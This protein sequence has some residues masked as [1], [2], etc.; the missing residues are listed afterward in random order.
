MKKIIQICM[1]SALVLTFG[2]TEE[3]KRGKVLSKEG[4][5]IAISPMI[6]A[7]VFPDGTDEGVD[8]RPQGVE[9]YYDTQLAE[10]ISFQ[11]SI[12]DKLQADLAMEVDLK[13]MD[14]GAKE[15][16]VGVMNNHTGELL[17]LT[18]TSKFDPINIKTKEI[19]VLKDRFADFLFEP[20]LLML[21]VWGTV[22]AEKKDAKEKVKHLDESSVVPEML[23]MM[24]AKD[25]LK[26]LNSFGFGQPSG[27]DLPYDDAGS[28]PSIDELLTKEKK[29]SLLSGHGMQVTFTQM[30]KAYSAFST[31]GVI[32]TPHIASNLIEGNT[33]T[34]LSFPYS[35]ALP[36][37]LASNIKYALTNHVKKRGDFLMIDMV[38]VGGIIVNNADIL[39]EG[40]V[41]NEAY[42][43]FF[44]FANDL[45][46]Q[47]YTIGVFL[48][49]KKD[50]YT[51]SP[52][53]IV[54]M[55]LEEMLNEKLFWARKENLEKG[56]VSPLP[57]GEL[58]KAYQPECPSFVK[59]QQKNDKPKVNLQCQY[60]T[61]QAEE[62]GS[63]VHA[64]LDGEV[65]FAGYA[66]KNGKVLFVKHK[67]G[68]HTIYYNLDYIRS[69]IK[70]G[71]HIKKGFRIG[72]VK[73]TLKFQLTQNGFLVDP[74]EY[75]EL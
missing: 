60:I 51:Y 29:V 43:A 4:N 59:K 45:I 49:H 44:G 18:R 42:S 50:K 47:S 62:D 31:K 34:K 55:V 14:L 2:N 64:V 58:V 15:T 41:T 24:S 52:V 67:D 10:G 68:L 36:E 33:T 9:H 66:E 25:M 26:G 11:T 30:L 54:N 53:P 12:I 5:Y 75:L 35:R 27:I 61:Y 74:L 70:E 8:L 13:R 21:P 57:E 3:P 7:R 1:V 48:R 28:I 23:S 38:S 16:F 22:I 37:P 17:M 46:G 56:A 39:K 32:L 40:N 63:F 71:V 65:V 20:N 72:R 73:E 6:G 69:G 19:P